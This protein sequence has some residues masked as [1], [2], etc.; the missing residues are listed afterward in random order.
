MTAMS[1]GSW[2]SV[3]LSPSDRLLGPRGLHSGHS[4]VSIIQIKQDLI[5]SRAHFISDDPHVDGRMLQDLITSR[6][7][8]LSWGSH[9]L[10]PSDCQLPPGCATLGTLHPL[11]NNFSCRPS[12]APL[13]KKEKPRIC[14]LKTMMLPSPVRFSKWEEQ[15]RDLNPGGFMGVISER[16]GGAGCTG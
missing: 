2:M 4:G 6:T 13:A 8:Y 14:F 11:G 15:K 1:D 5:G 10:C 9:S 12:I 7:D 3:W 16:V